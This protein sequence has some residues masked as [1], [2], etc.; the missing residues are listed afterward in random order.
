VL[1]L[2]ASP[3][4]AQQSPLHDVLSTLR[5]SVSAVSAASW[6]FNRDLRAAGAETVLARGRRLA[7]QC[8]AAVRALRAAPPGLRAHATR[9]PERQ[10][11]ARFVSAVQRLVAVLGSECERPFG[12][13][14]SVNA[15]SLRAWGT[16]HSAR[17]ERGVQ[18]Y[19]GALQRFSAAA[20]VK[21][22]P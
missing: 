22:E 4:H 10:E 8:R 1:V 6:E 5:D 18:E 12:G 2:F 14:T 21:L 20:G 19:E 9:E 7:E 15:D 11:A 3:V 17:I 13:S 16:Y